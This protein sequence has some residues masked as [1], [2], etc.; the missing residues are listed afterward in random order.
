MAFGRFTRRCFVICVEEVANRGFY[1]FEYRMS[2]IDRLAHFHL[3]LCKSEIFD[4]ALFLISAMKLLYKSF[5]YSQLTLSEI[6][7]SVHTRGYILQT[8]GL[9]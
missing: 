3:F 9:S 8:K 1:G 5:P 2:E 6:A 4:Y 7:E